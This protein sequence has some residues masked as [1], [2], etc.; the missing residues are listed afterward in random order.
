M[1]KSVR[2]ADR[3]GD[4]TYPHGLRVA[5]PRP[6]QTGAIDA[7]YREIGVH[8]AADD[9]GRQ[10]SPVRQR[11]SG[12][13]ESGFLTAGVSAQ[14]VSRIADHVAVRQDEAVGRKDDAGAA[15]ARAF[16]ADHSRPDLLDGVNDGGG[17]SVEQRLVGVGTE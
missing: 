6:W 1:V 11:D 3:D 2:V 7:K 5:E 4:L 17:I 9:V 16:D 14:A 12:G 15:A 13:V 10:R 8:V